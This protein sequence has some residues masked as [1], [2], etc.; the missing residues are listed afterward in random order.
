MEYYASK[1]TAHL[2]SETVIQLITAAYKDYYIEHYTDNFRLDST[3]PDFSRMEY[4]DI[5][6][7][8]DKET[9]AV[10]NYLYG[11][12]EKNPSFVTGSGSTFNSIAGKVYQF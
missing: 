12:A 5:V 8:L 7:Y 9:Q 2:D 4:M 6:S 11:M 1:D 3:E 10:L